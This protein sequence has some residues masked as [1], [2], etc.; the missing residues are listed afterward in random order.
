MEFK[1]IAILVCLILLAFCLFK[2]ITRADKSRLFWRI[3]ASVIAVAYFTLLI[4]PIKYE[5]HLQQN[6]NE[7]VLLTN[8]T[9]PDSISKIKGKKYI[10]GSANTAELKNIKAVPVADLSYFLKANPTFQKLN[11]YGYGLTDSELKDAAGH[12]ISFHPSAKSTGIISVNWQAKLKATNDLLVQ[13]T[14][15]NAGNKSVKLLLKGLGFSID[16]LII[17]PQSTVPFSFKNKPKQNGKA[18]YQLI[19]LQGNDTISKEPVPFL[20]EDQT[21]MKV[22]ILASFPDFEYKFLKKW[23]F[24]NQYPLAFRSQISKNK[25]SSDFLNMDSLSL[26][27]VNSAALKRF[28]VLIIDEEELASISVEERASIDQAVNNGMGLLIR[29]SNAKSATALSGRISRYETPAPKEKTLSL[30][31]KN[32]DF[33]LTKLPFEQTLFLKAS[34]TDQ[35]LITDNTNKILVSSR[36]NGSGKIIISSLSATYNWLLSGNKADY[37]SYWA[38]LISKTARKR[39]EIQT[40]EI[41]PQFPVL[42]QKIR[43]IA[44]FK[45]GGKTPSIMI[46]DIKLSPRQNIE[47]PFQWDAV[48]WPQNEGWNDLYINQVNQS[49]Y[50]YKKED[51]QLLK[52]QAKT[53][54][55]QQFIENT[56]RR[57][58]KIA[59]TDQIIQNEISKWWF[60]AG[61]L[62]AASFLWHESRIVKGK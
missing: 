48:S 10:L 42:N 37:A 18:V 22:L 61:F 31:I 4:V 6:A 50:V 55:M 56:S 58:N 57:N 35:P 29:I 62:L 25:Y 1:Y 52:N 33:K 23:L 15:Q 16:S 51:W 41:I 39:A 36:I 27:R 32:E 3:L 17:N 9:N 59:I 46:N 5:T 43:F 11:I 40:V 34:I 7:I 47:L 26:N 30:N 2:E 12:E 53:D 24:D 54:L 20:V 14:Y 28:D 8:G 19:T 13:G 44:D 49:F 21:P 60:F 38:S 45:E